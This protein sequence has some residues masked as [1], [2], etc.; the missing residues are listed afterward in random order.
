VNELV[1]PLGLPGAVLALFGVFLLA[2][3]IKRELGNGKG[4]P[5]NGYTLRD[6]SAL[7]QGVRDRVDDAE[8]GIHQNINDTRHSIN[9]G[10]ERI[11]DRME[12]SNDRNT[13][14]LLEKLGQIADGLH[15][16][17]A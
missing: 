16:D 6:A 15:R 2:L 3:K 13:E 14:K 8:R 10:L 9:N 17:R 1:G 4:K 7:T 5:V 11:A 12:E